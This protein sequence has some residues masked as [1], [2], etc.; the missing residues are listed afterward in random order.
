MNNRDDLRDDAMRIGEEA[1]ER[2]A[3]RSRSFGEEVLGQIAEQVE[4]Q[5]AA[6]H[7]AERHAAFNRMRPIWEARSAELDLQGRVDDATRRLQELPLSEADQE[8]WGEHLARLARR[9]LDEGVVRDFETEVQSAVD[10]DDARR[11]RS[12]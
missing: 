10:E 8:A 4:G 9:T 12:V 2:A 1:A 6:D 3:L 5:R 11:R 7:E